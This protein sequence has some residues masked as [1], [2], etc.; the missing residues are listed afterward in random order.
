M[1]KVWTMVVVLGLFIFIYLFNQAGIWDAMA[2]SVTSAPWWIT[3]TFLGVLFSLYGYVNARYKENK[4]ERAWI[5][6]E[7]EKWMVKLEEARR[8][9]K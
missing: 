4:T 3:V 5:E 6:A 2:F 1:K 8:N 9:K 7:G